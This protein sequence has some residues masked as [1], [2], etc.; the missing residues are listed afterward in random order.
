[1]LDPFFGTGTTG[2]VA[3]RLGRRFIGIE[4]DPGYI[5]AARE[6]HR[7]RSPASADAEIVDHAGKREEPRIPFGCAGRA[8]PAVARRRADRASTGRWTA[9]GA[10]RRHADRRRLHA[11][12][13]TRSAPQV[14]GAPAC[15]GWE[16]WHF[17]VEG[18]LVPIDLLR[19][20]LRAELH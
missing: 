4:R 12:R 15:N 16:F 18:K 11:A 2:A 14:Q 1:M 10:R 19:Q 9:Q 20:K 6:A 13:S 3:K 17:E 7:R 5:A 8:R